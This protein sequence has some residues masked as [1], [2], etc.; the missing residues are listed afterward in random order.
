MLII[1]PSKRQMR[2]EIGY[3]WEGSIN[4]AR[5]GD[6]I[7]GLKPFFRAERYADGAVYAVGQVQ[8]LIT[9]TAPENVPE[10]PAAVSAKGKNTFTD[11][12]LVIL[13]GIATFFLFG[14]NVPAAVPAAVPAVVFSG[15]VAAGASAAV[16]LPGAGKFPGMEKNSDS[17][18]PRET[19]YPYVYPDISL[20]PRGGVCR[21]FEISV[22]YDFEC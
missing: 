17:G 19:Q 20:F 2:L 6:I 1:V 16:A 3:G 8:K 9:G 15:A 5:A 13:I 14:G 21:I 12:V 10:P 7:R 22:F 18:V 4:D 11:Y